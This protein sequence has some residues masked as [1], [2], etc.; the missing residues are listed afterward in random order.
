M[1][2]YMRP[3][4]SHAIYFHKDVVAEKLRNLFKSPRRFLYESGSVNL[5]AD[6]VSSLRRSAVLVLHADQ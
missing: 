5:S 6:G 1:P 2:T 3:T 4:I